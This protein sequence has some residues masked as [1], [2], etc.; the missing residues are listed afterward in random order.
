M[1][2]LKSTALAALVVLSVMAGIAAALRLT[3]PQLHSEVV[4]NNP[5]TG[6]IE[7]PLTYSPQHRGHLTNQLPQTSTQ[8][9]ILELPKASTDFVGYW[10]GYVHSSIHRLS[11][12]LIGTGPDRVSVIFGRV[13]DTIYMASELY[14]S[15]DQKIVRHPKTRV[16]S[17]RTAIVEYQSADNQ[18]YYVCSH[19]FQLDDAASNI[20]YRSKVDV[21]DLTHHRLMGVVTGRA[22]LKRLRTAAEHLEFARPSRLQVP[23]ADISATGDF[24][25]H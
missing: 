11:P 19:R 18:L 22:T 3:R 8:P 2:I 16:V 24:K 7:P 20:S 4:V 14:G 15:H 21:Y 12:D 6:P 13:R 10:G 1:R 25:P 23:R 17:A 5:A 9:N